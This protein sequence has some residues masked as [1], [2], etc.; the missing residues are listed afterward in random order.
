MKLTEQ[1]DGQELGSPGTRRLGEVISVPLCLELV[2]E[3][4][5]K[6]PYWE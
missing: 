6:S 3:K 4:Q 2:M 5:C 1:G